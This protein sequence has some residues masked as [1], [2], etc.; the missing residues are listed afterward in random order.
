MKRIFTTIIFMTLL[1]SASSPAVTKVYRTDHTG[2][3]VGF[4]V[5]FGSLGIDF[6]NTDAT[7]DREGSGAGVFFIGGA[8]KRNLLI[9]LD[10]NAWTKE[11]NDITR[12]ISTSTL[13]LTYYPTPQFFVKGGV[14]FASAD[15]EVARLFSS[16]KYTENGFGMTAGAGMEFRLTKHF[17]LVPSTQWSYQSFDSFKSNVFS[18]TFN[19]GWYW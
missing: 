3:Y 8:L 12:T 4:G 14:G 6:D 7:F 2:F 11:N 9:G 15:V 10:A 16:I 1:L 5:G 18:I 17:A 19:I 13:C